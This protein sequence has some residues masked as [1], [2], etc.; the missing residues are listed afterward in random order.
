MMVIM[1]FAGM[2]LTTTVKSLFYILD[3]VIEDNLYCSMPY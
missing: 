2:I 1:I 3:S